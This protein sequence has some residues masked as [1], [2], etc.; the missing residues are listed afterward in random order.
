VNDETVTQSGWQNDEKVDFTR[1]KGDASALPPDAVMEMAA[2]S[3]LECGG[4][5]PPSLVDLIPRRRQAA[6]LQR[7]SRV[8]RVSPVC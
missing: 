2:R 8:F 4:L 3:A 1:G 5:T 7:A 6:A